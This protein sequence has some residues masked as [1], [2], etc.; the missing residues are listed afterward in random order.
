MSAGLRVQVNL[1]NFTACAFV[2]LALGPLY[3]S[4]AWPQD[5]YRGLNAQRCAVVDCTG[6]GVR[7]APPGPTPEQIEAERE[8]VADREAFDLY[9]EQA[10]AATA[11]KDYAEALRLARERQAVHDEPIVRQYIASLEQFIL[12]NSG[13]EALNAGDF[14]R[15]I[16]LYQQALQ[17]DSSDE[18]ARY[19]LRLA[20]ADRDRAARQAALSTTV[21]ALAATAQAEPGA[22]QAPGLDFTTADPQRVSSDPMVVDARQAPSGLPP[23]VEA[24]IPPSPAGARV[25]KGFQAIATHDWVAAR[26]W[27]QDAANQEPDNQGLKRLVD[28]AQD[29]VQR[30]A[31]RGPMTPPSEPAAA[32]S[33]PSREGM[34]PDLKAE[35][36]WIDREYILQSSEFAPP[37]PAAPPA[38]AANWDAFFT[39]LFGT[40]I[41][42]PMQVAAPRG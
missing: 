41:R 27:F 15:A 25:R 10:R 20:R 18:N 38:S 1:S 17:N 36:D 35:L 30:T 13:N 4:R 16:A 42:P 5:E 7:R 29:G 9:V 37:E 39:A 6:G 34:D 31:G 11:R 3:P 2:T 19:D 12:V 23:S 40:R 21:S 24:E 32:P 26:A 14:D 8:A 28:L 33:I 22:P